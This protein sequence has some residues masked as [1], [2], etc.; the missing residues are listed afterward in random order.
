MSRRD[1]CEANAG[2]R[3]YDLVIENVKIVN[4]FTESVTEGGVAICGGY[5]AYAGPMDFEY[6]ALQVADGRGM[7][8][9]PGLVDAHMHIES[10]MMAPGHFAE[11][12][13]ANGTTAVCADPHEIANVMGVDGVRAMAQAVKDMPLEVLMMAPSTIP[14]APGLERSGADVDEYVMEEMLKIEGVAGLGEV[15]DFNA[16]AAADDRLLGVIEA[17]D[18]AGVIMDGHVP[19][20]TGRRLQTFKAAGIEADHTDMTLTRA[21]EKLELGFGIEVQESYFS[22]EL[23]EYLNGFPLQD[24]IMIVTDD[25]PFYKL[26]AE[27]HLNS[28][29]RK[30]IA[31]GLEPLKAVRYATINAAM[32]LRLY[33]R[34]AV[35][36]GYRADIL[37]VPDLTKMEPQSVYVAGRLTAH[38]G[39]CLVHSPEYRFPSHFY[40][41]VHVLP[42]EPDDLNIKAAGTD[43]V[44]NT[45]VC[46]KADSRT[47]P[48]KRRL[49]I[50]NGVL[51]TDD[52]VKAAVIYRHGYG[53]LRLPGKEISFGLLEGLE[54]FSG[55]IATTYAH[56]SHNLVVIGTDNASMAAAGNH[57]I[58]T[59]GGMCVAAC[60]RVK[61]AV[62]LPVAGLL[63]E[64]PFDE[65]KVEFDRFTAALADTGFEHADPVTF[66]TLLTLAVAMS[67]RVTD[68][69]IVDV[70]HKRFVPML[71]DSDPTASSHIAE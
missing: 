48:G 69:G 12:V 29:L 24:R 17:A 40:G 53:D 67:I 43:A 65:L 46:N 31:L 28:N 7:Y 70:E 51:C 32:R 34:G 14:S 20:L 21:K 26:A 39:T 18:R 54:G 41:S 3:P 13:L 60:G 50:K 68:L 22:A 9:V 64:K 33:D 2:K 63:S 4:V 6:D 44:A 23:M 1:A 55:A 37:L 61:A 66:I 71:E 45:I 5:I 15:M 11:T 35:S 10:S 57:L 59:G 30:A 19:V 25:V 38:E 8:A 56:D 52:I 27:G 16:V 49:K 36:P 58:K 42:L 62:E 47:K